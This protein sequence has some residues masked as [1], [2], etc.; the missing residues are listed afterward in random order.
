[1]GFEFRDQKN[2][3][4]K[5]PWS[6]SSSAVAQVPLRAQPTDVTDLISGP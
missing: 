4:P 6:W 3:K 5:P 1:M 2:A